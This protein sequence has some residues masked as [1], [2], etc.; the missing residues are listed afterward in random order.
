[1]RD[2]QAC[3]LFFMRW[4]KKANESVRDAFFFFN[5]DG[6]AKKKIGGE[7][8]RGRGTVFNYRVFLG[9]MNRDKEGCVAFV[10]IQRIAQGFFYVN[11]IS[12][13]YCTGDMIST[14]RVKRTRLGRGR[15]GDGLT[16]FEFGARN[17]QAVPLRCVTRKSGVFLCVTIAC[18]GL[19]RSICRICLHHKN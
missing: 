16:K 13:L 8:I 11:R 3:L 17:R 15:V 5:R 7:A 4:R 12:F 6:T 18:C 1:M 10:L 19:A 14:F 2:E 9:V